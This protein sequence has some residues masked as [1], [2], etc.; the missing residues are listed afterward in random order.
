LVRDSEYFAFVRDSRIKQLAVA[1]GDDAIE[2]IPTPETQLNSEDEIV[3]LLAEA[4]KWN[5]GP[6]SLSVLQQLADGKSFRT[7]A[8]DAGVNIRTVHTWR[9]AAINELREQMQCAG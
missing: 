3:N 8:S 4:S 1:W 2:M 6:R 5:L 9:R 7:I